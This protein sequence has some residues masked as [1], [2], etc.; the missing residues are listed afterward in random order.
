MILKSEAP[1]GVKYL[2]TMVECLALLGKIAAGGSVIRF[3]SSSLFLVFSSSARESAFHIII[4][5]SIDMSSGYE[6]N[7][8]WL[9]GNLL[10]I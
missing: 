5:S 10:V 1:S 6:E 9:V 3:L 8:N 2:Q 4:S 7:Q